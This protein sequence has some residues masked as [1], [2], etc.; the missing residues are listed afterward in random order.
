MIITGW[1][2]TIIFCLLNV[3]VIGGSFLY[4]KILRLYALAL[5]MICL[6]GLFLAETVVDRMLCY[7]S[8]MVLF[9]AFYLIGGKTYQA[10]V[11][12]RCDFFADIKEAREVV[13]KEMKIEMERSASQ[14]KAPKKR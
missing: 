11:Q 9:G 4:A 10:L 5:A 7:S 12:D 6:P 2:M 1:L 8:V 14:G 3:K 13:A